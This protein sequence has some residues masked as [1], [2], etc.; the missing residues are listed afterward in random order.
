M[1][2]VNEKQDQQKMRIKDGLDF[3]VAVYFKPLLIKLIGSV[4]YKKQ[5][6]IL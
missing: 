2:P 3:V 4:H 5:N 1:Q 6:L